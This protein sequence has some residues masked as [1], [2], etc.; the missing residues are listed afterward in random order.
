MVISSQPR[1][2]KK[3]VLYSGG[4][5]PKS[6]PGNSHPIRLFTLSFRWTPN[7]SPDLSLVPDKDKAN[8]LVPK[9]PAPK[10]MEA[11]GRKSCLN[12]K[13]VD[14]KMRCL[15]DEAQVLPCM[16]Q[17]YPSFQPWNHKLPPPQMRPSHPQVRRIEGSRGLGFGSWILLSVYLMWSTFH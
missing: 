8:G 2:R 10:K 17:T 1:I 6:S 11:V 5:D 9:D 13:Q 16:I 3:C 14:Q 12:A 7:L 15:H 4:S